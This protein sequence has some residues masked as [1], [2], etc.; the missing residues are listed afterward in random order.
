MFSGRGTRPGSAI[1]HM[2]MAITFL[3]MGGIFLAVGFFVRSWL[4]IMFITFAAMGGVFCLLGVV[5]LVIWLT[6]SRPYKTWWR[7]LPKPKQ[8]FYLSLN[9]DNKTLYKMHLEGK[10]PAMEGDKSPAED[11]PLL[12]LGTQGNV[13]ALPPELIRNLGD[14]IAG[15]EIE[16][17][18]F[19]FQGD[20]ATGVEVMGPMDFPTSSKEEALSEYKE[21]VKRAWSDGQLSEGEKAVLDYL[22][23]RDDI[24]MED[25][26]SIENEVLLMQF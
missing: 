13:A 2:A 16:L 9:S 7:S 10:L 12:D 21:I 18:D 15:S 14:Y 1:A 26:R 8:D 4:S 6:V 19:A 24:T 22:R 20:G 23:A 17:D 25:H 5:F 3:V 11:D